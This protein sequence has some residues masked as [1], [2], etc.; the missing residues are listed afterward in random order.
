LSPLHNKNALKQAIENSTCSR[1]VLHYLGLSTSGAAYRGLQKWV[2]IHGLTLPEYYPSVRRSLSLEDLLQR[3]TQVKSSQLLLKLV[4]AGLKENK[5]EL[6]PQGPVWNGKPLTLHLDHIDG[7]HSNNLLENLRI[8]C[9]HCHQQTPTFGAK[10]MKSK[11]K[12]K[13][14]CEC[15]QE[16][17]KDAIYCFDCSPRNPKNKKEKQLKT[18]TSKA[19]NSASSRAASVRKAGPQSSMARIQPTKINWP[20]TEEILALLNN[21]SFVEVGRMLGVSDNSIRKHLRRN[22][23]QVPKKYKP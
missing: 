1:E 7:D 21:A 18:K 10:N 19:T 15:G 23:V 8:L 12:R 13:Y 5:C 17:T 9:P 2:D 6:C 20:P 16:R 3:G 14:F 11:P 4:N 22:G